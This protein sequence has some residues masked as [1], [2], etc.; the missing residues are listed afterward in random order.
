MVAVLESVASKAQCDR[1][2]GVCLNDS[3]ALNTIIQERCCV[4]S[5]L[6]FKL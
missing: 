5:F 4:K 1:F 2:A 3:L 6:L